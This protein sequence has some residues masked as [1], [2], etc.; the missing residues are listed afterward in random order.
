MR[1]YREELRAHVVQFVKT[2]F[3]LK[4]L[5]DLGML[6]HRNFRGIRYLLGGQWDSVTTY[7]WG[8]NP[9]YNWGIPL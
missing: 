4:F 3:I 9:T 1:L 2:L 7:N 5:R 8:Y 6:E